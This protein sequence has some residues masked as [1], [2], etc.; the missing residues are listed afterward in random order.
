MRC[1][2]THLQQRQHPRGS[3]VGGL[4]RP[5]TLRKV[6]HNS[7]RSLEDL[8]VLVGVG[9]ELLLDSSCHRCCSVRVGGREGENKRSE[10][11]DTKKEVETVTST[12]ECKSME[13][14]G[15]VLVA[16]R[17]TRGTGSG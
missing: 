15:V 4:R 16:L 2:M 9:R 12:L 3:E 10:K 7:N 8:V 17:D 5:Q 6:P 1:H 13:L 14:L 11:T